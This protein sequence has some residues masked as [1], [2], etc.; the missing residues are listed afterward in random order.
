MSEPTR[1]PQPI[2]LIRGFGGLDVSDEIADPYQGFNHGTVYPHRKGE[3]YI[4]E[5]LVL[6]FLKSRW[7]YH[8]ATNVVGYYNKEIQNGLIL[9]QKLQNLEKRLQD[10]GGQYSFLNSFQHKN[11]IHEFKRLQVEH[12]FS[13]DKIV[14]DPE[15]AL[16]SLKSIDLCRTL[17]VFRYYDLNDRKFATY[18]QAL[19]RLIDLIRELVSIQQSIKPKV[20]IIAHSMGGLLVREAVQSVY[21]QGKAKDYINKIVTLG[22]PHQGITFQL[23]KNLIGIEAEDEIKHFHPDFQ[24]NPNIQKSFVNFHK[25]FP[26][27]RLL[28]VVGTNYRT[29]SVRTYS[30]ANRLFPMSSEYGAN[31]NRSDGLVKL[32][33]AQIPDAPRTF[34]HKCH[35]GNDSLVSS[36]EAFEVATRFFF[37]NV[38]SRLRFVGGKVTRGKD[39]FGKS[40]FFLGVCIKP[41][42]VDFELFH[43]SKEAENCYGPFTEADPSDNNVDFRDKELAFPWAD[44]QNLIWEG[45]LD[46]T[47]ILGA[48][49]DLVMR[50]DFYVSE[51]DLY[52]IGFSDNKIF[53]KQYYIRAL[54]PSAPQPF[55]QKLYLH[56]N[57]QFDSGGMPMEGKDG[58]W[59]FTVGDSGF[60]GTF[61]IEIDL[62]PDSEQSV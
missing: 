4:Y 35:Y 29:Y 55:P 27:E 59:E 57:E 2:I 13:G 12:F 41:R 53:S 18:G 62:I 54:L 42:G 36:R 20:N 10:N 11:I 7:K 19:V 3:N 39:F 61:R 14:I 5:G 60:A 48:E 9:D 25:Y 43:Q 45:Y 17:W 34:I 21:P 16:Q 51:R 33:S 30:L 44:G 37:G 47:S 6:R 8:D 50:V 49:N 15:M 56:E 31:Y 52:G 58:K 1:H 40:E 26:L 28:T 46:T 23:L 32:T 38:R 22:T 24:K